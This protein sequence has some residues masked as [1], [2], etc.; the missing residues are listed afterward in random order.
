MTNC[1][2]LICLFSAQWALKVEETAVDPPTPLSFSELT[3]AG[4]RSPEEEFESTHGSC[5][6]DRQSQYH[7]C[8]TQFDRGSQQRSM[9]SHQS[10]RGLKPPEHRCPGAHS[11]SIELSVLKIKEGSRTARSYVHEW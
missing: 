11:L 2:F 8:F 3:L 4:R 6:A 10:L 7:Y 5:G 9:Y 1:V